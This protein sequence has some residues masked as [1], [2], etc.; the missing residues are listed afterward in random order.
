MSWTNTYNYTS[1]VHAGCATDWY[2]GG[3]YVHCKFAIFY[4]NANILTYQTVV[5]LGVE[6]GKNTDASPTT[7]S[8]YACTVSVG[9]A[10]FSS[11]FN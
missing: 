5:L 6:V 2:V 11:L 4:F 10:F 1:T 3:N 7:L 9:G 8:I